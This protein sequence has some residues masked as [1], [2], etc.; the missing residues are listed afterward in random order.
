MKYLRRYGRL[1]AGAFVVIGL[2]SVIT[3]FTVFSQ[4]V[5]VS[6]WAAGSLNT[7]R[8]P[9]DDRFPANWL[10]RAGIP[11][12]PGDSLLVQGIRVPSDVEVNTSRNL[13]MVY[14]PAFPVLLSEDGRQERFYSSAN[15]LGEALYEKGI[16]VLQADDVS[17]PLD[18][19]LDQPLT[20]EI[21]RAK[22][23]V[24]EIG[25]VEQQSLS[26][27]E[28]VAQALL[29]AGIIL[30]GGDYA[31]PSETQPLPNDRRI[32]VVR[33]REET[34]LTEDL[35]PFIEERVPDA[36]LAIGEQK[37]LQSGQ[38][39]IRTEKVR[40]RFENDLETER[41]I[42]AAW[43][44]K[45]P[46]SQKIAYGSSINVQTYQS[47]D[48]SIDYWLAQEVYITSYLDTGNPTASGVWPY[49]G[50]IAVPTAWYPILKGTSIFVPGYGVGTVL[51]VCPGCTGRPWIDVFIPTEDY[52]PWS[53][54][55]VVYFLPPAPDNFPGELP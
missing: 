23:V 10:Q 49:Y 37:V 12:F 24:I 15:S 43:V 33:V 27:G 4:T 45:Q 30:Q 54:T 35:I 39:G 38:T 52:V 31:V 44:T 29:D 16:L 32:Q 51:D 17:L 40:L 46:I 53:R 50:T 2:L 36:N 48:G 5:S 8:M 13:N 11:L 21:A 14:R 3:A 1:I 55:E 42:E 18:T 41:N 22:S 28:T 26:A 9:A 20:V 47:P 25:D 34:I 6:V 19:P 7:I